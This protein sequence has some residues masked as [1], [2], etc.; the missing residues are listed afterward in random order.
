MRAAAEKLGITLHDHAVIS[1]SGHNS[2][3]SMGLL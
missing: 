2:F 3:K 1:K